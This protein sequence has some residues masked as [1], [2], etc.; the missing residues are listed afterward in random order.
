MNIDIV[1]HRKKIQTCDLKD[2]PTSGE[3]GF[4]RKNEDS[5][6]YPQL[7]NFDSSL[8]LTNVFNF[9]DTIIEIIDA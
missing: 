4:R 1:L 5:I 3:S 7:L 9:D 2:L 6:Y 8:T